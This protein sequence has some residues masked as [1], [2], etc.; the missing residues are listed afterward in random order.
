M[1]FFQEPFQ[2]YLDRYVAGE[3]GEK[4]LLKQTEYYARWK[5]D[6]RLYR[7]ILVYA[8]ENDIPLVALNAPAE[9]VAR[10]SKGGLAGLESG[11]RALLPEDLSPPGPAYEARLR[12]VF[13]MHGMLSE[14]RFRRF[15]DVQLLWDEYMARAARDYLNANPGKTVVIL[16][17]SGHVA[18]ADA[19]PG[20]LARMKG[21][22]HAVVVTGPKARYAG[23]SVDFL[24]EERDIAL[25]P[26]GRMGLMLAG[27]E[28][29]VTIREVRPASP[30]EEAGF[31]PGDRIVGIAGEPI[32]GMDDV[33]LA[34]LDRAPG[35]EVW[36]ELDSGGKPKSD[37]RQ[38]RALTLL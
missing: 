25:E 18:Y 37:A 38:G 27:G 26:P 14:E 4:E 6:Y 10:V 12:P 21:M 7:D 32:R 11:E 13:T 1:E 28:A 30:A 36:V 23:G 34:L 16:A 29:G 8:R 24:F 3:I 15:T 22:D 33:R 20:R 17:G 35:E 9:L 5:Y 19:I 31:R 2:R